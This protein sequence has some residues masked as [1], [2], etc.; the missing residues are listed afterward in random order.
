MTLAAFKLAK[1]LKGGQVTHASKGVE[2]KK[3]PSGRSLLK[4]VAAFEKSG[5]AGLV[6]KIHLRGGRDRKMIA[7]G[8]SLLM[9]EVRGY[10]HPDRPTMHTIEMRV[11]GKF[12]ARNKERAAQGLPS[13]KYPSRETVRRAVRSLD[14]FQT[15]THRY[16]PAAARKKFAPVGKG[17]NLE[18]PLQRVEIDEWDIDL[19]TLLAETGVLEWFSDDERATLGLAGKKVRWKLTVA[20]C[21]TT[22]CILAMV[23]TPSA[24]SSAAIQAIKM[25][26][27][28]K[29]QLTTAVKAYGGWH[30]HGVPEEVVTDNGSTFTSEEFQIVCADLGISA[31]RTVAG[32]PELRGRIER[33][34]RTMG[35]NLMSE[36]S[37]RTFSNIVEKGDS[38]PG[39][40]ACLTENDL[41]TI[42]VCWVVDVYHNTEHEGLDG[43]TPV[44]CWDR[45]TKKF[46]VTSPPDVDKSR[47]IFGQKLKRK[48]GKKG[49]R[50][51]GAHY[52]SDN[53]A[54]HFL[55]SSERDLEIRW[56]PSDIGAVQVHI[57]A[58]WIT[59]PAVMDALHGTSAQLWMSA[60]REIRATDPDRKRHDEAV[61]LA[62]L[63]DIRARSEDA[64]AAMGLLVDDW[65]DDRLRR[66]EQKLTI[67]FE[68][69]PS[70][71]RPVRQG[72]I[73]R[74]VLIDQADDV[75][76]DAPS[77][78]KAASAKR[79]SKFSLGE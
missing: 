48:V 69:G 57:G 34:F 62:A 42:L 11:K 31:T 1:S 38:D 74:S 9:G 64:Q 7:E 30:M 37:V 58:K 40:R 33:F 3:F 6:D 19:I 56:L 29:G 73:G 63:K 45:L 14:P 77:K 41:A 52:Q 27:S 75:T 53:L 72:G 35:C 60:V 16:G 76:A 32:V 39:E 13:L 21:A 17:L 70:P 22:R 28:D 59:V 51:L 8:I 79:S 20:M 54:A 43:E 65:S 4:W 55:H 36:L 25:V 61:I 15:E 49:L 23:L 47:Q 78:T 46:C 24:K 71:T 44:Q 50:I 2:L 12:Q 66:E 67:G 10:M 68:S 18:R 5:L 26:L